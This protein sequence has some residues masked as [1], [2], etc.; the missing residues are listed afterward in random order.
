MNKILNYIFDS[1]YRFSINAYHT[2]IYH[3]IPD[4]KYLKRLFRAKMGKELNLDNPVTYNE[5]LQWLKLFD[6]RSE[7]SMLVD[8]VLVKKFVEE[9]I[10]QEHI[11]PTI[12]VWNRFD[13]IDFDKLPDQFVLK[14]NHDCG[15]LIIVKDKSKL[16][17]NKARKKINRCLKK[18][19]YYYG[20]E[21]PYKNVKPCI[22]AEQYMVD[23][24]GFELKDYKFFC[25]DGKP[26]LMFVA[27]DR[28]TDGEETKFDFYDM[29][30]NHLPFT[31]GHPNS[32]RVIK[33]PASFEKMKEFAAILSKGIPHARIDFYDINGRIYFGE[34]TLSHWSGLVPFKPD[35]WD[36]RIGS[37]IQLPQKAR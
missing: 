30:F 8:K 12:G 7:Y 31:N 25:F 4:E 26:K 15:G 16:D 17:I 13:E 37:W 9:R 21:W 6:R 33:K 27:S 29:D 19:Y 22:F 36:E 14:C 24:S 10:G 2:S 32:K 18:N 3:S 34:V 11:I 1:N 23:E 35:E 20:R 5:K 28:Q